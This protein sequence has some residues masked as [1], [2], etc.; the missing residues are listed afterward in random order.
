MCDLFTWPGF[1]KTEAF[2]LH[3][4][5]NE[6]DFL[7]LYFVRHLVETAGLMR[8]RKGY[9]KATLPDG[10]SLRIPLD[11]PCSTPASTSPCGESILAISAAACT[12]NGATRHRRSLVVVSVAC[13]RLGIEQAADPDVHDSDQRSA[14]GTV[15]SGTTAM[16]Q[17]FFVRYG[18]LPS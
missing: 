1:D 16:E 2:R 8:Q 11:K 6:P 10:R 3:K 7:P 4:V 14:G 13:Q 12:A 18:G 15:D 17:G 9:L 5:I